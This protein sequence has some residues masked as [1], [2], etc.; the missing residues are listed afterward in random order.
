MHVPSSHAPSLMY[1]HDASLVPNVTRGSVGSGGGA[2][3]EG[4]R[5]TGAVG[6]GAIGDGGSEGSWGGG[7]GAGT[8]LNATSSTAISDDH[9]A[10]RTL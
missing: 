1:G 6:I 5:G 3:G 4:G 9:E 8:Q 7:E 10:P 2:G